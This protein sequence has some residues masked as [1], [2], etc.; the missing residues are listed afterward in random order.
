MTTSANRW[1]LIT[2]AS[3]LALG[4]SA[5]HKTQTAT[6]ASAASADASAAPPATDSSNFM[7]SDSSAANNDAGSA[8]PAQ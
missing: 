3:V 5:C 8:A 1:L 4:A 7:A 2:A 6:D